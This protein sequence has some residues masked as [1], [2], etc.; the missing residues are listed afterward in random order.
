[1]LIAFCAYKT[2]LD[3]CDIN[4]SAVLNPVLT[5]SV[6]PY[7]LAVQKTRQAY[8]YCWFNSYQEVFMFRTL[9]ITT[10][11]IQIQLNP[12]VWDACMMWLFLRV[13][14]IG[15]LTDDPIVNTILTKEQPLL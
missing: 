7:Y 2:F 11:C 12:S 8:S 14:F 10:L 1:M 4:T 15:P 5:D 9:L 6:K 13:D 3:C